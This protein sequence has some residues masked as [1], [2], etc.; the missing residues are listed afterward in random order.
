MERKRIQ[1]FPWPPQSPDFN[2]IGNLW[3]ELERRIKEYQSK[4]MTERELLLIQKWNKIELSV[5]EKL[6][7][8]VP[9]RLYEFIKMKG[10]PT[11]Y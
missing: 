4:N 3:D 1:I 5:L 8:S 6:V 11:K 7:N 2:P 9:S 10:Y